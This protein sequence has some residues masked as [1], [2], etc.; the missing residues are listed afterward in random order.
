M[1]LNTRY[2][3][4]TARTAAFNAEATAELLLELSKLAPTATLAFRAM[5]LA[6]L[7]NEDAEAL[8]RVATAI[9]RGELLIVPSSADHHWPL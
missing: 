5:N 1:K 6:E 3:L 9:T 8:E 7:I 4:H 2:V